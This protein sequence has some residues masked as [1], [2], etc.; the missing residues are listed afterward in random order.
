MLIPVAGQDAQGTPLPMALV[1]DLARL[2]TITYRAKTTGT[3]I[4]IIATSEA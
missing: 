4:V 3:L 2:K 1:M